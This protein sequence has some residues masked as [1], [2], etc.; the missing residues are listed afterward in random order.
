M[1]YYSLSY[2]I[3]NIVNLLY[4]VSLFKMSRLSRCEIAENSKFVNVLRCI[5]LLGDILTFSHI[6]LT[7]PIQYMREIH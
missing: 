7:H 6:L 5:A 4:R 1:C 3:R 2:I